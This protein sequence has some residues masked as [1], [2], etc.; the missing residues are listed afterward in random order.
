MRREVYRDRGGLANLFPFR[1]RSS[2]ARADGNA[3]SATVGYRQ[4]Y[5]HNPARFTWRGFIALTHLLQ[6]SCFLEFCFPELL[7]AT[8]LKSPVQSTWVDNGLGDGFLLGVPPKAHTLAGFR[9]WALSDDVPEKLPLTFIRGEVFIDMSKEEIQTHAL[10]KTGVGGGL[11]QLNEELD[12]GHIFING[13]LVSNVPA[14]VCNNPDLVAVSFRALK[15]GRV[16]YLENKGRIMEIEGSPDLVVE[17][18]SNS[19]V[20]KDLRDLRDA[21][22]RARIREYWLIDARGEDIMFQLLL[23]RKSGYALASVHD[24][25]QHSRVF[26]RR[27]RLVR[28]QDR[29]GVWKYTLQSKETRPA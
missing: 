21:Y 24:G 22:H 4:I 15:A 14:K 25:W 7:M 8:L 9:A 5:S 1:T 17:I 16:R 10:V 3:H 19:S 2:A 11:F 18:V 13:V 6:S 12:F 27:F 29:A 28:K 20:I 26:G 23:W